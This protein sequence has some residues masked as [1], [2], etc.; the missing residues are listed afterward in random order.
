LVF[1]DFDHEFGHGIE[2][3]LYIWFRDVMGNVYLRIFFEFGHVGLK[4][5]LSTFRAEL[6]I[7]VNWII[8]SIGVY[9][10]RFVY[11]LTSFGVLG[12]C[13]NCWKGLGAGYGTSERGKS[14]F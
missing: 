5:D 4:V 14:P 3:K 9:I 7:I 12:I 8:I 1:L 6:E 11:L 2:N 10:D 13:L